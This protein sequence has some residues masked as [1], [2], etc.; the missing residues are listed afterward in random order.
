MKIGIIVHSDTGNTL[1]VAN[2]LKERLTEA[3]HKVKLEQ[4][5]AKGNPKPG[6]PDVSVESCP[7]VGK[8]D[9]LIFGAPVNGF[10]LSPTMI[11]CLNEAGSMKGKKV[12]CYVTKALRF[13]WTGGN[14]AIKQM[15]GPI[16][17]KGGKLVG[18]GIVIWKKSHREKTTS[19]VVERIGGLF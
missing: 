6:T 9:G 13:H 17:A 19:E 8:Y 16:E 4:I 11:S 15:K 7:D 3:G 1:S 5:R 12:A 10:S 18:S 14:R 2:R